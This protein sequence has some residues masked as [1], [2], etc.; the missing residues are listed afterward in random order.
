MFSWEDGMT[1]VTGMDENG[2]AEQH[3]QNTHDT[4][5]MGQGVEKSEF[6]DINVKIYENLGS[7]LFTDEDPFSS[8]S[9]IGVGVGF[10]QFVLLCDTEHLPT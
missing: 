4:L 9:R 5:V 7:I 10:K 2:T 8:D 3:F 1:N 6:L